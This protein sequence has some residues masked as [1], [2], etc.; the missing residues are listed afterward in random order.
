MAEQTEIDF[1]LDKDED[2]F[3]EAWETKYGELTDE[4][5]EELYQ[6]IAQD[7]EAKYKSGE[8]Q[9]G[10]VFSYKGIDVGHSDYST[11]NNWFLFSYSKR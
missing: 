1:Y 9:L 11:I 6:E 10:E 4:Q 5:L 8:H 2:A 3:L 7:I